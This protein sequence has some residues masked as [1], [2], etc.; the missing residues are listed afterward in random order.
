MNSLAII[1][2]SCEKFYKITIPK[3]IESAEKANIPLSCIY[4]VV[5][6]CDIETDILQYNGYH[7]VFCK[8]VNIDYNG[9]LYF[10]QTER[11]LQELQKYKHF[12][13]IHDTS[14]FMDFFWEKIHRYLEYCTS[15]IKLTP[16]YS[17]NIG[18]F[19]VEW[20]IQNK[21]DLFEYFINYD[22]TLAYEIKKGIYKNESIIREKYKNLF[23][24]NEDSV[25][26]FDENCNPIGHYFINDKI[27]YL[28]KIYNDDERL[29]SIYK[30]P[31]IIKF[32]KN[33]GKE[34]SDYQLIL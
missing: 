28:D 26:L 9:I 24:L 10:T 32:Q 33:Y 21:K 29:V 34:G 1:I 31:G 22:K 7:L 8:F 3:I 14:L 25:F 30:E 27:E 11:G 6:E 18:L 19:Q 5:G 23:H 15:Y 16:I 12:F 13:Y 20:F 4:V 2:N 17:K